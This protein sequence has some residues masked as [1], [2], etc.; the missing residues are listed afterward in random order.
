MLTGPLNFTDLEYASYRKATYYILSECKTA[1]ISVHLKMLGS[2]LR[3]GHLNIF[4][5]ADGIYKTKKMMHLTGT[6][7]LLST[8]EPELTDGEMN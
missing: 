8:R 6:N 5:A 1:Q 7:C 3:S 4:K 2:L